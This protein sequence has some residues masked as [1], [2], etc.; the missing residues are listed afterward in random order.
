[1]GRYRGYIRVGPD[2]RSSVPHILAVGDIGVRSVPSDLAL[3]HVAEAE[4][5]VAGAQILG[6]NYRQS[7]DHIPYIIFTVPMLAGAGVN[8]TYARTKYG[9]VRVGKYPYARNHR[10]HAIQPAIGFVKL[11]VGP[12][13]DDRYD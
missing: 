3:V 10:A 5:R 12:K 13:G 7:M 6:E 9:D 8:E 1:M 2:M 4:G 11:I